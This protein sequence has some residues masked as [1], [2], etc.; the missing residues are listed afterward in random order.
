MLKELL[1]N[2]ADVIT[3]D[4]FTPVLFTAII[5]LLIGIVAGCSITNGTLKKSCDE[6]SISEALEIPYCRSY[7]EEQ[8]EA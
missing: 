2:L 7:F 3:S 8:L 5:S 4:M 1:K 6:M